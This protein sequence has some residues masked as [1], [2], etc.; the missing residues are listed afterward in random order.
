M[1][2]AGA[3]SPL[4]P[5]ELGNF[6]E[7][8]E[9]HVK[10]N[11]ID[12]SKQLSADRSTDKVAT[13]IPFPGTE[14]DPEI[15]TSEQPEQEKLGEILFGPYGAEGTIE[16]IEDDVILWSIIDKV[17]ARG[18][19]RIY[20]LK[21]AAEGEVEGRVTMGREITAQV[22][23]EAYTIPGG[24]EELLKIRPT[25]RPLNTNDRVKILNNFGITL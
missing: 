15:K 12:L 7:T 5:E 6:F 14:L 23:E 24:V 19:L 2:I 20:N 25:E 8:L 21:K 9:V 4:G 3:H 13:L 22:L 16:R 17:S 18:I 11:L 10:P 1:I